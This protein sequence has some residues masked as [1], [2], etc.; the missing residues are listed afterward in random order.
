MDQ[1]SGHDQ[2]DLERQADKQANGIKDQLRKEVA[3]WN[4]ARDDAAGSL[5]AEPSAPAAPRAPSRAAKPT[6]RAKAA[7][8]AK[9][10]NAVAPKKPFSMSYDG[11]TDA[12]HIKY[13]IAR[14]AR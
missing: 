8:T 6:T 10:K 7:A 11:V 1:Q 9:Q 4:A 5:A 13:M 2:D 3:K 12:Q 14:G